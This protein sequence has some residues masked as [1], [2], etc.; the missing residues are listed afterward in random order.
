MKSFADV[1]LERLRTEL[2]VIRDQAR[3]AY[4]DPAEV[5]YLIYTALTGKQSIASPDEIGDAMAELIAEQEGK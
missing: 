2:A 4:A 1:Q 5:P 3:R